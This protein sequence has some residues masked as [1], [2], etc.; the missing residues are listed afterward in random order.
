MLYPLLTL[1][2]ARTPQVEPALPAEPIAAA[3]AEPAVE[4]PM[5]PASEAVYHA[6]SVRDPV[7]SCEEV[8]ALTETPVE[9]FLYVVA[10]A[11]QP[12]WVGLHAAECLTT[13]HAEEVQGELEA[14][15]SSS[16]THGLAIL[17]LNNLDDMPLEVAKAVAET[18][19]AG[20]EAETA[21]PRILKADNAAI[22]ALAE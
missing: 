21:R 2:C 19:L 12:P 10:H 16:Q 22:R 7:P 6:F 11:E 8:E 3:P 18:A 1:A 4:V 20:P 17:V 13:R 9:T 5:D 15:V 14:W